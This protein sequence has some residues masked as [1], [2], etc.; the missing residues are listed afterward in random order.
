MLIEMQHVRGRRNV[1]R[2]WQAGMPHGSTL[3]YKAMKYKGDKDPCRLKSR[4]FSSGPC[5]LSPVDWVD[6]AYTRYRKPSRLRLRSK[7]IHR[8]TFT[9]Q[10]S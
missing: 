2:S 5:A 3:E 8:L 4:Y 10:K 9:D 7:D 1:A 6:A